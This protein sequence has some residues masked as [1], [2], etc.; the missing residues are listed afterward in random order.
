LYFVILD[1]EK[2]TKKTNQSIR[3]Y[4]TRDQRLS[5]SQFIVYRRNRTKRRAKR[6]LKQKTAEDS[7]V[8]CVIGLLVALERNEI[9][10]ARL[11]NWNKL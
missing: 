8:H 5:E 6:K 9:V 4:L 1:T 11:E 2:Q 10:N 3:K 7:R